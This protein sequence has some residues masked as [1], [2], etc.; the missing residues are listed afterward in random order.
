MI[1][2]RANGADGA[3]V[4][5]HYDE[6]DRFYRA[7]WGI[8]LHHGYWQSGD[9]STE[10][11][12]LNLSRLVAKQAQIKTG[13]RVCDFG[14]GYGATARFFAQEYGADVTGLTISRRQHEIAQNTA[15]AN[16]NFL[17]GDGLVNNLPAQSFD[18]LVAIESSEHIGDK[19]AFFQEAHRLLRRGGRLVVS[20]W[21]AREQVTSFEAKFLLGPIC[22]E[23][24]LPSM[25][26][27]SE[28]LAMFEAAGFR[29][30]E[31]ADL[32]RNVRKTWSVCAYRLIKTIGADAELRR[33]LLQH[34]WGN[35]VFAKTVF[36]IWLAYRTGSMRY[37]VFA[38]TK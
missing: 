37:G 32:S 8:H 5:A 6:L 14:C 33:A 17:L 30:A 10:E 35:H 7:V 12:I 36:R 31:F 1:Y 20:A 23:G 11:A 19:P 21:L 26:A 25:A 15:G 28:Y 4:A 9:E 2:P 34:D 16:L 24:R 22:E 18:A 38:A 13:G 29:E 27:P 3:T